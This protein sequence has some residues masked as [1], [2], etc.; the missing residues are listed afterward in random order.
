[1]ATDGPAA[2]EK[3]ESRRRSRARHKNKT[4]LA[5]LGVGTG[6][7]NERSIGIS[8]GDSGT[9]SAPFRTFAV[10][11]CLG[12]ANER[13]RDRAFLI[14]YIL[15]IPIDPMKMTATP[16]RRRRGRRTSLAAN[17]RKTSWRARSHRSIF[18]LALYPLSSG[19]ATVPPSLPFSR[20]I[21]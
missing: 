19:R 13:K 16:R 12:F 7:A 6:P 1:M 8:L 4:E 20:K 21:Y 15:F 9:L 5:H 14:Y 18:L 10:I 3:K 2:G 11:G 17:F